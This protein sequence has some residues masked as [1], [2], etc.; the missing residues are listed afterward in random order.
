MKTPP[1]HIIFGNFKDTITFKKPPGQVLQD[2]YNYADPEDE[3]IGFY[4]FH[5]PKLLIRSGHLIKQ[6]MVKDFE[7]FPN[8]NFGGEKE[9]DSVGLVNLLGI[10]QPRWR[11]L[12]SKITSSLTGQKLKQMIPLVMDCAKPL[13]E[14]IES[15]S[16]ENDKWKKLELKD[17]S[18]RYTTDV[19]SSLAFGITTNSFDANDTAF[20]QAGQ[21]VVSGVKRGIILLIYVFVPGLVK[22]LQPIARKPAQFF[23]DIFEDSITTREKVG[24]KRGDFVDSLLALKNGEQNELFS[25]Y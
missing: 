14:F 13:I 16:S 10:R 24:N 1:T 23:R 19:I 15:R 17:L 18:S 5:Q 25:T 3:F 21:N 11:Y 2:I 12:R 22:F 20:W 4:I 6:I 7:I 9:I 8:R